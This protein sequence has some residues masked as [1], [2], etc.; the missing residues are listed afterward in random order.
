MPR[1]GLS[2][3]L[4]FA[5]SLYQMVI[6][7]IGAARGL[8]AWMDSARPAALAQFGLTGISFAAL[9]VAFVTRISR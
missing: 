5:V 8:P 7:M 2:P 4:A 1:L 6:P 9:T 3:D